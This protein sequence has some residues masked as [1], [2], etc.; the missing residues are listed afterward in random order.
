MFR[1]KLDLP[2]ICN[3]RLCSRL[4]ML[5]RLAMWHINMYLPITTPIVAFIVH[6]L[7]SWHSPE[8]CIVQFHAKATITVSV[9]PFNRQILKPELRHKQSSPEEHRQESNHFAFLI[10]FW[11]HFPDH[12][13]GCFQSA[14]STRVEFFTRNWEG[15]ERHLMFHSDSHRG[16]TTQWA[17]VQS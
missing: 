5:V 16:G 1:V 10:S 2:H 12:R 9:K 6:V 8:C 7:C 17:F 4:H 11:L 14:T 3:K 13:I 15:S